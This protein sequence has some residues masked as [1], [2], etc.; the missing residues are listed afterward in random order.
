MKPKENTCIT[1]IAGRAVGEL[2]ACAPIFI[3]RQLYYE[4]CSKIKK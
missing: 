3:K 4:I 2:E 1:D